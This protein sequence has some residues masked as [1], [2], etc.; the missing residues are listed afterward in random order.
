[1]ATKREF[2]DHVRGKVIERIVI[3]T[4]SDALELD[5]QFQDNTSF[6]VQLEADVEVRVE[7]AQLLGWKNG[8]ARILRK[9]S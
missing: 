3:V 1:V 4:D 9:L 5:I 6:A 7:N 2:I 8:N